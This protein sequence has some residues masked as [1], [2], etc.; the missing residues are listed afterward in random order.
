MVVT[1]FRFACIVL[2]LLGLVGFG[3][4]SK[5]GTG[6]SS[7]NPLIEQSLGT[8]LLKPVFQC[9][10][11]SDSITDDSL[12]GSVSVFETLMPHDLVF[13]RV[14]EL[15]KAITQADFEKAFDANSRLGS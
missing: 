8:T 10:S 9:G 5:S 7:S 2:A 6:T 15:K 1:V 12:A 13:P 4:N 11:G 14:L 3:G